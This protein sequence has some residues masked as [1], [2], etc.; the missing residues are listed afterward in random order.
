[1]QGRNYVSK[2][3]NMLDIGF[4]RIPP[5]MAENRHFFAGGRNESRE[6]LGFRALFPEGTKKPA[7]Q[8]IRRADFKH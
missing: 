4:L 7:G 6:V 1:M 2:K 8:R 5:K 3:R